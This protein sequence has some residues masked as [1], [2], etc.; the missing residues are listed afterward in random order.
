MSQIN[1][2]SGGG[3][4]AGV[5]TLSGDGGVAVNPDGGGNID[6]NGAGGITV[7]SNPGTNSLTVTNNAIATDFVADDG[8]TATPALGILNIFSAAN[9]ST[10]A[11]G[12][13]ITIHLDDDVTL[14]GTFTADIIN[15]ITS[16]NSV[17]DITTTLGDITAATG[18]LEVQAGLFH[19]NVD[20]MAGA[21]ITGNLQL[22]SLAAGVM[23]TTAV[24]LVF[25]DNGLDGQVLI[26]GGIAP[27][28][29]TLTG[30]ANHITIANAANSITIDTSSYVPVSFETDVNSPAHP[31]LGVIKF[32]GAIN[33]NITVTRSNLF[34]QINNILLSLNDAVTINDTLTVT[35]ATTLNGA[36]QSNGAL[37]C[38]GLATFNGNTQCNA[39]LTVGAAGVFTANSTSHLV[40]N[41]TAD[42]NVAVGNDLTVADNTTLGTD[43]TDIT[44]IYGNPRLPNN[45]DGVLVTNHTG[46]VT[47]SAGTDGQLLIGATGA[48]PAWNNLTSADGSVVITNTPNHIN[49][50]ANMANNTGVIA[51]LTASVPNATGNWDNYTVLFNGITYTDGNYNAATG[52]YTVPITGRYLITGAIEMSNIQASHVEAHYAVNLIGSGL[53]AI[54]EA[55]VCNPYAMAASGTPGALALML[56]ISMTLYLMA[57]NQINFFV[58]IGRNAKVISIVG[59]PTARRYTWISI[60]RLG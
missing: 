15:A 53:P 13:T 7:T 18:N 47:A 34:G 45:A 12:N 28:W 26:G 55:F 54:A 51:Y 48:A 3:G 21:E 1:L 52:T 57:G 27:T 41:V 25:S 33:G 29:S 20:M 39:N 8:N 30:T 49:L 44:T 50:S 9:I 35:N 23:Q 37:T 10:T 11:A 4:A 36:L 60:T 5:F 16:L 17:G 2:R 38:A 14:P 46:V 40:G 22:H 24:G 59:S 32:H 19:A 6:I 56:P 58:T 42:N 43:A 31:V